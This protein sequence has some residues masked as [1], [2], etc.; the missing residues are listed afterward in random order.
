VSLAIQRYAGEYVAEKTVSVVSL[1]NEESERADHRPGRMAIQEL[2]IQSPLKEA[3]FTKTEV[4][5]L[6]KRLGLPTWDK[7]SFACLASRFPYGE[8]ITEEGLRRV[9]EAEDFPT[10]LQVDGGFAL[11]Q[12]NI[13]KAKKIWSKHVHANSEI[14]KELQIFNALHETNIATKEI[15]H[16]LLERAR[17]YCK[18]QKQEQL[19]KEKEAL[20]NEINS[21]LGD[22]TFFDKSIPDYKSYASVQVLMNAWRGTGFKGNLSELFQLEET[23]LSHVLTNKNKAS[24]DASDVTNEQ[25]DSLVI[26]LMT[27]KLMQNTL[28][29]LTKHRRRL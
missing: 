23:V 7:P 27:E 19:D 11:T 20:I 16:S 10:V 26:K 24:F 6:S 18:N 5:E 28:Q 2:G 9:D 15:G 8:E 17:D 4:R 3:M 25:V 21:S 1:P 29:S 12:A 14:F 13:Q 22:K